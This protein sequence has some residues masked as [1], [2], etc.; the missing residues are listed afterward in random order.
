MIF[1]AIASSTPGSAISCSR[2]AVFTFTFGAPWCEWC[3]SLVA[4]VDVVFLAVVDFAVVA[5]VAAK[6]A[7]GMVKA[8]TKAVRMNVERFM[9]CLRARA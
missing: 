3:D 1:C 7:T 8:T 2:V 6:V 4:V 5:V 9:T